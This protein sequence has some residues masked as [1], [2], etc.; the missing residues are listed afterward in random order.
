MRHATAGVTAGAITLRGS[1]TTVTEFFGALLP[2]APCA[3]IELNLLLP[4]RDRLRG[5]Q[6]CAASVQR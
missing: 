4:V 5:Q 6:A 3:C 2:S 1:T